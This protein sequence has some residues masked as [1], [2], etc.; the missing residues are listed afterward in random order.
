MLN[1]ALRKRA[2]TNRRIEALQ[3]GRG[4][5]RD[6]LE[7]ADGSREDIPQVALTRPSD[8]SPCRRSLRRW[9]QD[10]VGAKAAAGAAKGG[11]NRNREV[12]AERAIYTPIDKTSCL[13]VSSANHLSVESAADR[14]AKVSTMSS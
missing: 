8:R 10:P 1:S 4:G 14:M 7:A 11:I 2:T 12:E 6:D 9:S 13:F 5:K 3:E